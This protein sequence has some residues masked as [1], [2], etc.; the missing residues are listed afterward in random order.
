MF[1]NERYF[2]GSGWRTP[3]SPFMSDRDHFS[4]SSGRVGSSASDLNEVDSI[5][6]FFP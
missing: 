6:F 1:E 4:D 3:F 2:V 5:L